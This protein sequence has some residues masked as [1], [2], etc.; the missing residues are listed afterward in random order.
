MFR[1]LIPTHHVCTQW[2]YGTYNKRLPTG[3][4]SP[5][6]GI[7]ATRALLERT[8]R[9]RVLVLRN[10]TL[11]AG[12]PATG[13]RLSPDKSRVTGA[14]HSFANGPTCAFFAVSELLELSFMRSVLVLHSI[15]SR[16]L[17]ANMH[18]FCES[19]FCLSSACA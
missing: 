10:L 2:D 9:R 7:G 17:A 8:F 11:R 12:T 18:A 6:Q 1:D 16:F 5:I 4:D 19:T 13:V 14:P 3:E 15:A